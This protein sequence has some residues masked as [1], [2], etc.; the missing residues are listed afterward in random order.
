MAEPT[1][2]SPFLP[3]QTQQQQQPPAPTLGALAQPNP[4]QQGAPPQNPQDLQQKAAGWDS[5]FSNPMVAAGLLQ[6]G[7]NVLAP[8]PQ[9]VSDSSVIGSA[10]GAA[11]EAVGR[12]QKTK[13]EQDLAEAKQG[14]E[15]QRI[16]LEARRTASDEKRAQ[17]DEQRAAEEQRYH[18]LWADIQ[19][20]QVAV[21]AMHASIAAA[22]N[23][24]ARQ[25]LQL[26]ADTANKKLE[27]DRDKLAQDWIKSQGERADKNDAQLLSTMYSSVMRQPRLPDEPP[28]DINKIGQDFLTVRNALKSVKGGNDVFELGTEQQWR[29]TLNNPTLKQQAITNFGQDVVTR[30][31]QKIQ[32]LD[33]AA[34]QKA[35]RH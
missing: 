25:R 18:D 34:T 28:P 8:R 6:F 15:Q 32:E 12:I 22:G 21:S 14:Q 20:Q 23:D 29:Q 31:E 30:A 19:K 24:L 26:E 5:F 3:P 27:F 13:F 35:G 2:Q 7:I 10:A 9:G 33:T 11:G 4:V 16:G 17:T 1:A